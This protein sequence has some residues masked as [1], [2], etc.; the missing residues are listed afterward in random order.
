M[1]GKNKKSG[2]KDAKIDRALGHIDDKY[3]VFYETLTEEKKKR[4]GKRTVIRYAAACATLI[5][6]FLCLALLSGRDSSDTEKET[7][8]QKPIDYSEDHYSDGLV[9][10]WGDKSDRFDPMDILVCATYTGETE[11]VDVVLSAEGNT[12]VIYKIKFVLKEEIA[13]SN[14]ADVPSEFLLCVD[15]NRYTNYPIIEK[16]ESVL[17]SV[18]KDSMRGYECAEDEFVPAV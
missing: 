16:G 7:I 3:I 2:L 12:G 14:E 8:I 1:V 11:S 6:A 18:G 4:F 13:N 9:C 15:E 17:L 5:A 10:L